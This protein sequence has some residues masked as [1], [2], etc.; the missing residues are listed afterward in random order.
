S[1]SATYGSTPDRV[2]DGVLTNMHWKDGTPGRFPDWLALAWPSPQRIGRVVVYT[3]NLADFEVQVPA[4]GAEW[5]T[6]AAVKG[7]A[8]ERVE[9]SFEP[10]QTEA[11]RL[12][13]T[14]LRP[15]EQTSQ[16]WEVEAYER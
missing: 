15:G 8:G 2:V 9:V 5:R 1:S 14:A 10:V 11:V 6:L 16:I 12:L 7:A 4:G 13:I 3:P